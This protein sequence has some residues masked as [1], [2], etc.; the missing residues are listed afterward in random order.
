MPHVD[1]TLKVDYG[2]INLLFRREVIRVVR[3]DQLTA[4]RKFFLP[5]PGFELIYLVHDV[6]IPSLQQRDLSLL[7]R[8]K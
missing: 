5:W 6:P 4:R 7:N 8:T 1:I 2:L 3:D